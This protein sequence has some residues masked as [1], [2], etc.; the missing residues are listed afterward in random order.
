M[1]RHS[2]AII[3]LALVWAGC[4]GNEEGVQSIQPETVAADMS[5]LQFSQARNG[6]QE[7]SSDDNQSIDTTKKKKSKK[8]NKDK[9]KAKNSSG[10]TTGILPIK[11]GH[12]TGPDTPNQDALD[13]KA[14]FKQTPSYQAAA[15]KVFGWER[16][17]LERQCGEVTLGGDPAVG[18]V[19]KDCRVIHER[20]MVNNYAGMAFYYLKNSKKVGYL[21]QF[22]KWGEPGRDIDKCN[23][24]SKAYLRYQL[25]KQRDKFYAELDMIIHRRLGDAL[26]ARNWNWKY[27]REHLFE[28]TDIEWY[29]YVNGVGGCKTLNPINGDHRQFPRSFENYQCQSLYGNY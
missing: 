4:G 17:D 20:K 2:I 11:G 23:Q 25:K 28:I 7:D 29:N 1:K 12:G 14:A 27:F 10:S 21:K 26:G 24:E 5:F 22:C 6:D 18:T 19:R 3:G 13:E 16:Y 8:S 15:L 9:S